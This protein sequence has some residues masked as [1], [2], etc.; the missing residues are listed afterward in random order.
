MPKRPDPKTKAV[1]L[2]LLT[3]IRENANLSQ[4]EL[5]NRLGR[6]QPFVSRYETGERRLD[7]LELREVSA[8]CNISLSEFVQRLENRLL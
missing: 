2:E 6:Y 4:E 7:I 3:E 5:A 8:A 1:L